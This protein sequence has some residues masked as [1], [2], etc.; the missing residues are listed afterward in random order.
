M[1]SVSSILFV[2]GLAFSI[3]LIYIQMGIKLNQEKI[4]KKKVYFMDTIY[5][6][7]IGPENQDN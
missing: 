7:P 3:C 2:F 1:F 6:E 4:P 5:E